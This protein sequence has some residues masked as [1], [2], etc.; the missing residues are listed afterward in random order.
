MR[1][2]EARRSAV[3]MR[4]T[5]RSMDDVANAAEHFASDL[6]AFVSDQHLLVSDGAQA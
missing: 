1:M 2:L 6:S 3:L 4:V 5:A